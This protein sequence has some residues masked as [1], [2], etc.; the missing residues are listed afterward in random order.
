MPPEVLELVADRFKI[1]GD[2]ARLRI[3]SRLTDGEQSVSQIV[4]DT[5]LSQANASKHLALLYSV[6]FVRRRKE[7]LFTYYALADKAVLRLC[8]LMC[9]RIESEVSNRAKMLA[10]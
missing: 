8:D 9:G 3:L 6:G 5:G 4:D 7:R 1:L 2:P 10:K